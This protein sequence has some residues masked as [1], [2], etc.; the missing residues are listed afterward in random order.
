MRRVGICGAGLMGSGIAQTVAAGGYQVLLED[1]DRPTVEKSLDRLA[2]RLRERVERGRLSAEDRSQ[3]LERIK[4]VETMDDLADC[5]LVIEAVFENAAVKRELFADLDRACKAD[6]L[7]ATNTSTLSPT[8]IGS[9]TKRPERT[10]GLHFFNPAPVMR[11]VEV[12]PGLA[13]ALE[14]TQT[15]KEFVSSLGKTPVVVQDSA[16][17]IVSR[18]LIAVR[19][20]AARMVMEGVATPEDIDTAM[21]LGAGWPMGPLALI[22]LI[23]VDLHVVNSDS[24]ANELGERFRPPPILR[25]MV[26][27]GYFGQ[28][29]GR[30]FYTYPRD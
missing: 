7:L 19:N 21:K 15:L 3:T 30:G 8:E 22:D 24:L 29:N 18:I 9:A 20:E 10:A 14:T 12:I 23:G 4:A 1:V 26:R 11:L 16:G 25:K 13:T 17:G 27:A 5:D 2:G 28:K 6:A